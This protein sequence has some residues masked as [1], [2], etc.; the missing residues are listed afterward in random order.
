MGANAVVVATSNIVAAHPQCKLPKRLQCS[1]LTVNLK[2][3]VPVGF[4]E[5]ETRII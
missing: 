4:S 1:A 5:A 3:V 2:V